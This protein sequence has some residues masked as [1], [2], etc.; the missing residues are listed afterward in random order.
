MPSMSFV[1]LEFLI[2][3][4]ILLFRG[5]SSAYIPKQ[6]CEIHS[7]PGSVTIGGIFSPYFPEQ[8]ACGGAYSSEYISMVESMAYATR[9]VN[10]RDDLLQGV[11]LG[12]E[13]RNNCLDQ[14][15]TAWSLLTMLSPSANLEYEKIC[16]AH[17]QETGTFIG[18]IGPSYSSN[19]II[20][21]T[22]ASVYTVPLISYF[23][24]SDELSNRDRFPFFLRTVPP[25]KFQAKAIVDILLHFNWKYIALFYSMNSYGIQGAVQIQ[26]LAEILDICIPLTLPISTMP[27]SN[28]KRNIADK[29]IENDKVKVLVVFVTGTEAQGVE[30]AIMEYNIQGPF[31]FVGSDGAAVGNKIISGDTNHHVVHGRIFTTH[32]NQQIQA[33][34]DYYRELPNK[35]HIASEWYRNML[36]NIVEE[37][38]CSDWTSCPIPEAVKETDVINAVLALAFALHNSI[39][40]NCENNSLCDEAI[41]G[42][43]LLEHLLNVSFQGPAG[44]FMFDENGD[45]SGKYAIKSWQADGGEYRLVDV[46]VWDPDGTENRLHINN[47]IIAWN[48]V[49]G[50]APVSLCFERCGINEV[51]IPLKKKCCWGCHKC[52]DHAKVVNRSRCEG[53]SLFEWPNEN[54]TECLPINPD[55]VS[56]TNPV[57]LAIIAVSSLGIVLCIL[58]MVGLWIYRQHKLIKASS[59]ELSC[60]NLTGLTMACVSSLLTVIRPSTIS[61]SIFETCT[62]LCF[63]LIF[64][65]LLFKVNRIWR[66]FYASGKLQ[67]L[68]MVRPQMQLALTLLTVVAQVRFCILHLSAI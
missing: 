53:C 17:R 55:Y 20:A 10:Q 29:L 25:D 36:Q 30:Q 23:S 51:P 21:T 58:A 8:I 56:I 60:V 39:E 9:S 64:A 46:G 24:T 67:R 4:L 48:G 13:I 26:K 34:R 5:S 31:T 27:S 43:T 19:S 32:Y 49:K 52:P 68:N 37:N 62:S 16:S 11:T 38:N 14:D 1:Q 42:N 54:Y 50:N 40:N 59:R 47:D 65:P 2:C 61:C 12:Y 66:I 63:S 15:I 45:T 6:A 28:E 22:L 18:L 3:F 7:Y 41:E 33:F 57:M 35:Q 44:H